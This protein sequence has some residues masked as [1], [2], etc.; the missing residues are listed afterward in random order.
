[1]F[2]TARLIERQIRSPI[3]ELEDVTALAEA[4]LVEE[5]D[6]AD[7]AIRFDLPEPTGKHLVVLLEAH[8][9][10][11]AGPAGEMNRRRNM[12]RREGP[13][14]G[15]ADADDPTPGL[16]SILGDKE[17]AQLVVDLAGLGRG[18]RGRFD[19]DVAGPTGHGLGRLCQEGVGNHE[20][21]E[22][23]ERTNLP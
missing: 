16:V 10:R 7:P 6:I 19:D 12:A 15:E 1:P 4:S 11:G 20:A 8:E 14:A 21:A 2:Q 22:Q 13:E 3:P 17:R 5:D 18:E 9:K 23:D